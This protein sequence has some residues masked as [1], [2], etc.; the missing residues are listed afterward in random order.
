MHWGN[1]DAFAVPFSLAVPRAIGVAVSRR[2]TVPIPIASR[3][4]ENHLLE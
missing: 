1:A 4:C 2:H 3:K